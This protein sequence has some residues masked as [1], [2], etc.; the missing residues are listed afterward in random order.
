M[1]AS[2]YEIFLS[3]NM[4]MQFYTIDNS[5]RILIRIVDVGRGCCIT[6]WHDQVSKLINQIKRFDEINIRHPTSWKQDSDFICNA[7]C[8][9]RQLYSSRIVIMTN[10]YENISLDDAAIMNLSMLEF[11]FKSIIQGLQSKI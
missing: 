1:A 2:A 11:N 10:N 9:R 8:I 6:L 5:Q 7:F 4:T 3:S